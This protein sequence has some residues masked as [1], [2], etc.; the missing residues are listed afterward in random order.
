[1]SATTSA[2]FAL[3][4]LGPAIGAEG[5][6]LWILIDPSQ[7]NRDLMLF[8]AWHLVASV[9]FAPVVRALLPA[10]LRNPVWPTL[11]WIACC[12]FFI[13]VFGV[14]ALVGAALTALLAPMRASDAGFESLPQPALTGS[15]AS[16]GARFRAAGLQGMLFDQHLPSGLRMRSMRVLQNMPMK[17]AGPLLSRLLDD[18]VEDLRLTAHALLERESKRIVE[19]IGQERVVLE[20]ATG[21]EQRLRSLRRMAEH[22]WELV[23]GGL[24]TRDLSELAITE[25]L[26]FADQALELAPRDAQLWLLRGKLLNASHDPRGARLAYRALITVRGQLDEE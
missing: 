8:L 26:N 17:R 24:A 25:G 4:A 14:I 11:T 23:Y 22:Y 21:P 15:S 7:G 18:P 3:L 2:I 19:R 16:A 6:A 10:R 20:A 9:L 5:T 1:M 12:G 13:P